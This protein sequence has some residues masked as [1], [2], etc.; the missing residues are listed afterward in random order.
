MGIK[1]KCNNQKKKCFHEWNYKGEAD[2]YATCPKCK[3]SVKIVRNENDKDK[4][5][6]E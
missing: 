4:E 2:F 5:Q 3:S 1:L 6:T